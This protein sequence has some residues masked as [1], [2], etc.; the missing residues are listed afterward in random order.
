[1]ITHNEKK[2]TKKAN[3]PLFFNGLISFHRY[4]FSGMQ[5]ASETSFFGQIKGFYNLQLIELQQ[6]YR[7][8]MRTKSNN[9]ASYFEDKQYLVY[10]DV[11]YKTTSLRPED[12]KFEF[13]VFDKGSGESN[14]FTIEVPENAMIDNM[15]IE[16]VQLIDGNIKLLTQNHV[17]MDEGKR[18]SEAHLYTINQS[19]KKITNHTTIYSKQEIQEDPQVNV[20][21][22]EGS[23]LMAPH[24]Q[25][26]FV[27]TE[28]QENANRG[29]PGMR[30]TGNE[31]LVGLISFNL[32]T[33]KKEAIQL[34]KELS[35]IGYPNS[36]NGTTLY[37]SK[38][39]EKGIVVTPFNVKDQ[40]VVEEIIVQLENVATEDE[41]SVV[42]I[43]ND[44]LYMF[45]QG[46]SKKDYGVLKVINLESG[47]LIFDGELRT[48][49]PAKDVYKKNLRLYNMTVN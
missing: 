23:N 25:V 40:K 1:M 24:N 18:S 12:F 22:V 38:V 32:K 4:R 48:K 20:S 2:V 11:E 17:Q 19:N 15:Y 47:E 37:F 44:K 6:K 8:F 16:D 21:M 34:P 45:I 28:Y 5:D 9:V 13:S 30:Q 36:F 26:L 35:N 27:K 33:N 46:I 3:K 49:K 7:T 41:L 31:N 42:T 14:S 29:D 39:S 10:A 43:E